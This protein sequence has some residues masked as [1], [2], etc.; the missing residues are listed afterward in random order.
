MF[1]VFVCKIILTIENFFI[2]WLDYPPINEG[3][4]RKSN[5]Y[6]DDRGDFITNASSVSK[7]QNEI[8]VKIR[9]KIWITYIVTSK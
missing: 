8:L 1:E 7:C 3:F 9:P 2:G 5:I 4:V 6:Y